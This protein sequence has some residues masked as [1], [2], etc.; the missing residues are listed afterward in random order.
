MP[1]P[2]PKFER[3]PVI[4]TVL[5]VQFDRLAGFSGAHAGAYWQ[6]YLGD[7]FE[8]AQDAARLEDQIERFGD[9]I[10]WGLSGGFV[11]RPGHT[12]NRI[13]IISGADRMVQIQDTRFIY[14]WR[15][16]ERGYPSYER[17]RPEFF[18][19]FTNFQ[20]YVR[21]AKL[22]ELE[23]NQWEV[24]YLNHLA[25][26]ELWDLPQDW[27]RI[28]P[29][30][31][32]PRRFDLATIESFSS[33]WHYVIAGDRGRLHVALNHGRAAIDGPE[34]LVLTLTARG[35]IDM[36]KRHDLTSGLDLGHEAI[37]T[38]FTAMTSDEAHKHWG[39]TA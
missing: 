34:V 36:Q 33:E 25:R 28:F 13:Q 8:T 6:K 19:A 21:D 37:V 1:Q 14:N 26:G 22:G 27:T 12:P 5:G 16:R 29:G 4:E 11:V 15:K 9:D 23:P 39:R 30:L 7:E 2:L 24:T 17:L 38:T 20:A 10:R 31:Y 35:P 32:I 3:P 18:E